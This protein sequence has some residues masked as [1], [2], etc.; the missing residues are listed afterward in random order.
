VGFKIEVPKELASGKD[1]REFVCEE[2]AE[3]E[4]VEAMIAQSTA[5]VIGI[6]SKDESYLEWY[7]AQFKNN[8]R[9]KVL[10]INESQGVEF[11]AVYLVGVDRK[12]FV[13]ELKEAAYFKEYTKVNHDLLYVALT[14]AMN[15]LYVFGREPLKTIVSELS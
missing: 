8:S 14:R 11:D 15:E 7:K 3:F 5:G 9:V 12:T 10:T 2:D 6:L 1:V 13:P 4:Q